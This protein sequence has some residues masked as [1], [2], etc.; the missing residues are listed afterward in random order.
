MSVPRIRALVVD[1]YPRYL[2]SMKLRIG[3]EIKWHV[4]WET[5]VDVDEG[6]R[7]IASSVPPFDLVIADLMF[8]RDDFPDQEPLGLTLVE[9]ASRRSPHTFILAISIGPEHVHDLMERARQH[10][11]HHVVRRSEFSTESSVHSPAAIAAE[12]RTHLLNNGTVSTC[13]VK[14]DPHDPGVQGLLHQVGGATIA[15]L[16]AE[17]LESGGHQAEQV[18]L[19]YLTPGAS[20][21]SVCAVTAHIPGAPRVSHILKLSLSKDE[22]IREADRGRR[23]RDVFPSHLLIQYSPPHAVGPVNGWYALGGP[24]AGRATTLRSWLLSAQ[25]SPTAVGDLMEELFVDGLGNAYEDCQLQPVESSGSFTFTPRRQQRILQVLDELTEALERPDGGDLGPDA[26]ATLVRDVKAFVTERR[27]PNGI[28]PRDISHETYVCYQHGDLH[29]GN[30]LVFAGRHDRPLLIDTSHCD[31]AHWATDLACLAVD[32]LMRS[33]DAGT[34]SMLFTGFQTWRKLAARFGDGG[35]DLTAQT[36]TPAT[37]AALTALSWLA[38]NLHRVTPTMRPSLSQSA[39]RWEWHLAFA[40][41][42]LRSTS[43]PDIPHAK[44]A[45]AFAAAHDQLKAAAAAMSAG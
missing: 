11:A 15:R 1:D 34:E 32:L 39:H 16:Y 13:E 45:L 20:G 29:A 27:L 14:A 7:L 24:F 42:L 19:R 33:V 2:D 40:R 3:R 22:L 31:T 23:A 18:E 17:V 9:E 12:I 21:A 4:D 26:A 41:S 28:S 44:R 36:Q 35:S 38:T 25:A 37:S 8:P 5:A 10:G 43:H 30:V 6:R